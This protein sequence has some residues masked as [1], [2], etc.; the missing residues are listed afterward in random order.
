MFLHIYI[1]VK[2]HSVVM[3][4]AVAERS[5]YDACARSVNPRACMHQSVI[6]VVLYVCVSVSY[7]ISSDITQH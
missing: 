3:I 1:L 6:V 5:R 4:I 2:S 7:H